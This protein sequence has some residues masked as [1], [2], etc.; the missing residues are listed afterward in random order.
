MYATKLKVALAIVLTVAGTG[1]AVETCDLQQPDV[2]VPAGPVLPIADANVRL[3]ELYK[4]AALPT[5]PLPTRPVESL[6]QPETFC[7][8]PGYASYYDDNEGGESVDA[9][10]GAGPQEPCYGA[11]SEP[12]HDDSGW[13][14]GGWIE[15][16]VTFNGGD[17]RDKFNGPIL[18]NDR[19]NEY[20]M[21]Q[22]WLYAERVA[23]NGGCGWDHGGRVDVV[24]GTDARFMQMRDGL[25]EDWE[26]DNSY[27]LAL[28]RFYYDVAYNDWTFRAGRWDVPVGYEPFDATETFFY[29]RSYNF[30]AQPGTMLALMATRH[31][32][33]QTSLSVGMHR[34]TD[35]FDDTDGKDDVDFVGG[36]SWES[37]DGG[38][39]LD[40]YVIAEEK[41][42]GNDTLHYS[43]TT[44][45][46]LT[47]YW[48]Y[49][50][51]WYYGH[52]DDAQ[53]RADWH[54]LN[55]HLMR[56]IN[57]CWSYGGRFEWFR[58]DDGFRVFSIEEGN[59]AEGPFVGDFYELTFAVNY[60]PR[61]NFALRPEIRWD[62][63][64]SETG[65][66][67][68][69][70]DGRRSDQFIYSIDAVWAF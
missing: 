51:E 49:V 61:E 62:W 29:S 65:G 28:L 21:N 25:E 26:Q 30:L 59:S 48:E 16:G 43:I 66:P 37:C 46:M 57:E 2:F 69:F 5:P 55:Q 9:V 34:G 56:Q 42:I 63:F 1:H 39:W 4:S 17:P 53:Q 70:H 12:C 32:N 35:Q 44:G 14:F 50:C 45:T 58:D 22:L 18:L 8:P 10:D 47:E 41:G 19:A 20:Q 7:V 64:D 24:Y 6:Q 54:G 67:K 23:D 68:P 33:D 27:E 3:P 11:D 13:V 36:G 15:Q 31:L 40:A 38:T 52:S 60:T